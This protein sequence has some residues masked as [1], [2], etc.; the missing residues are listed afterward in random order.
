MRII[1]I[2]KKVRIYESYYIELQ[3]QNSNKQ[4]FARGFFSS[5]DHLI[6]FGLKKKFISKRSG[7]KIP[8]LFADRKKKRRR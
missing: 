4:W 2:T 5:L 8:E 7:E 6:E 1:P 3:T